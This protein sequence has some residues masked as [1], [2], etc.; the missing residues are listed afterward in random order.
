MANISQSN[1]LSS[2]ID[3]LEKAYVFYHPQYGGLRV[4]TVD[5]GVFFCIEDLVAIT[6]IGRD[7]LFPVLADTEGKVV[8]MYIEEKTKKVP[9]A[10]KKRVFF[11]EYFG[12]ADK[13]N[14][15]SRSAWRN[16]IF[17]DSQMVRD[18]TIGCSK[19]PERKLFYKWV[20]DF[21]LPVV[22][23]EYRCWNYECLMIDKVCYDPLENPIDIRYA[24]D[25]LYINGM[26]IN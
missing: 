14:R 6:D 23:D 7:T 19:D 1:P 4:V 15:N 18:M 26:R 10:F 3:M 25:G 20:K 22:K 2:Y 13:V 9:K 21:I 16:M 8:E 5:E 17:V 11:G 12:K 24:T